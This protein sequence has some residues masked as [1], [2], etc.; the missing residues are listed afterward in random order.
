MNKSYFY[1]N[2]NIHI[3]DSDNN[4]RVI[5]YYDNFRDRIITFDNMKSIE[6]LINLYNNI[7]EEESD[8]KNDIKYNMVLRICSFT[9]IGYVSPFFINYFCSINL[10]DINSLSFILAIIGLSIGIIS[11]IFDLSKLHYLSNKMKGYIKLMEKL[12]T[13]YNMEKKLYNEL[14]G[15]KSKRDE[16]KF[17]NNEEEFKEF[18]IDNSIEQS[19]LQALVNASLYYGTNE[20]RLQRYYI[21]N[22]LDDKL[23]HSLLPI[24]IDILKEF[25]EE[26]LSKKKTKYRRFT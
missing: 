2:G 21:K 10:N 11:S 25:I 19:K 12:G 20:L 1:A 3:I 8:Y 16:Y 7:M 13:K 9:T 6:N 15:E 26:D 17:K 18:N 14:I 24:E 5:E 22:I 23:V 4:K